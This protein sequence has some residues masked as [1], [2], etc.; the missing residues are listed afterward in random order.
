MS[1]QLTVPSKRELKPRIVVVG[2]GGAGG[3]AVNNMIAAGLDGAEFVVANTDAQALTLSKADRRIQMGTKLTEGL[4]AGSDPEIGRGAAEEALGDVIDI[5]QGAHM[6][7]ITAG[8]GGGTGTGAAPVIARAARENGVLTVGVV[9]KP[10]EF[11]GSRRMAHAEAGIEALAREV[12]TLIIIPNQNLFRIANAQ[13]TFG[14]AFALADEVLHSGVAGITDLMVRP[15]LMNLDFADVRTVMNEMGK[16]MMGTGEATGDNRAI[17]AAEAAISNPL[18]EDVS[19]N[20]ARG[21]LVNITGGQDMTLYDVESVANRIRQE[22][23]KDANIKIGSSLDDNLNGRIRVSVFATGMDVV[24]AELADDFDQNDGKIVSLERD[25]RIVETQD[26]EQAEPEVAPERVKEASSLPAFMTERPA[27]PPR[28]EMPERSKSFIE[29]VFGARKKEE[30]AAP[31]APAVTTAAETEIAAENQEIET[32]EGGFPVPV[33]VEK[34]EPTAKPV[35][36]VPAVANIDPV[37]V[38]RES[39]EK[40][41]PLDDDDIGLPEKPNRLRSGGEMV[42]SA[43]PAASE[44]ASAP[45]PAAPAMAPVSAVATTSHQPAIQTTMQTPTMTA[46]G[47]DGD[48]LDIPTFLRR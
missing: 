42:A 2:V 7:F 25:I 29:R 21:I 34:A 27:T 31:S 37:S 4:G 43:K 8:M 22:V 5:L 15:G 47:F 32:A 18:L 12:D 38:P 36:E 19:M 9:T 46:S 14:E 20:G 10:F 16:A 28:R 24:E 26:E 45:R 48:Q 6:A 40:L 23:A 41:L 39:K 17:D 13:T 30:A 35:P 3:N 11:E 1:I 44:Q 33:R